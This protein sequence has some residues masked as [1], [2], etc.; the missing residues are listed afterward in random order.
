[1]MNRGLSEAG[2]K[3]CTDFAANGNVRD[4]ESNYKPFFI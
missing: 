2:A 1:M 3:I 4:D